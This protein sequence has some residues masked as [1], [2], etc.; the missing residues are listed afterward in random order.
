M[1]SIRLKVAQSKQLQE[2][3]EKIAKTQ[4]SATTATAE[5]EFSTHPVTQEIAGGAT[6]KNI[7]G[8]LGGYG[9]LFSFIGFPS[10]SDPVGIIKQL[11]KTVKFEGLKKIDYKGKKLVFQYDISIPSAKDFEDNS[12]IPWASGRSWLSGISKGISGLGLYL[13]KDGG[14]RSKGGIQV[15]TKIRGSKMAPVP[16][17]TTIYNNFI[18]NFKGARKL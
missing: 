9:N 13:N 4:T 3:A 6:A 18:K 2:I 8:T 17:F 15:K 10:G 1:D 11:W 16:Y 7:S 14:G 12:P 5:L